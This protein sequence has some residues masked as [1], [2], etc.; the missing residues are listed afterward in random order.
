MKERVN[1]Q[2][3]KFIEQENR[4]SEDEYV[5]KI[6][7]YDKRMTILVFL[8]AAIVSLIVLGIGILGLF[9]NTMGIGIVILLIILVSVSMVIID[10]NYIKLKEEIEMIEKKYKEKWVQKT[11]KEHINNLPINT[12]KVLFVEELQYYNQV[13]I[14]LENNKEINTIA[15]IINIFDKDETYVRYQYLDE[16][17]E[18]NGKFDA[19]RLKKGY[20]NVKLF[21][22]KDKDPTK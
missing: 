8:L 15:T 16:D 21:L 18:W 11:K 4:I 5:T 22:P 7:K 13:K 1:K 20:Y 3:K 6:N 2:L 12:K 10:K 19:A 9:E 17:L 14:T